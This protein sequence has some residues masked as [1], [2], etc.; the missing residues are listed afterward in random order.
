[1]VIIVN[2]KKNNYNYFFC[3]FGYKKANKKKTSKTKNKVKD[4]V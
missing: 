2:K 3:V 4:C 1:L